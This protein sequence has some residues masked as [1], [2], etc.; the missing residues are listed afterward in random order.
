[1]PFGNDKY[2][3]KNQFYIMALNK[4]TPI[5]RCLDYRTEFGPQP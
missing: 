5:S 3:P 1:V 2:I 4:K